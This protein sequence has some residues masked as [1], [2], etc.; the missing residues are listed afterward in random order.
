MNNKS[1][2]QERNDEQ[3]KHK[4]NLK[5]KKHLSTQTISQHSPYL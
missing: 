5:K 1:A 2:M 3:L 4:M